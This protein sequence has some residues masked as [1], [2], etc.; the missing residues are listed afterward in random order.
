MYA[1]RITF[2]SQLHFLYWRMLVFSCWSLIILSN[3]PAHDKY[4][5][6]K[7]KVKTGK[8]VMMSSVTLKPAFW[9]FI[10][11]DPSIS[12]IKI[13]HPSKAR[14]CSRTANHLNSS[15]IKNTVALLIWLYKEKDMHVIFVCPSFI[16]DRHFHNK[17]LLQHTQCNSL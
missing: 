10:W 4:K 14:F 12:V 17:T 15:I 5:N 11:N 1:L 16:L 6:H 8:I 9:L 2:F 13:F 3:Y 7:L